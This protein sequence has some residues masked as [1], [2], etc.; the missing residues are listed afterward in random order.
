M[1]FNK[2]KKEFKTTLIKKINELLGKNL[3]TNVKN[4]NNFKIY[5][6]LKKKYFKKNILIIGD[7]LH[8]VHPIAGQG[9]NLVLRDIMK[10]KK[11]INKNIKLGMLIKESSLLKDFY[12]A[13]KP[14]NTVV[15]LGIDL[16]NSFFKENKIFSPL[17]DILLKNVDNFQFVK[18]ISQKISD[19]GL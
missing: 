15:G 13:R 7:G 6:N 1:F 8:T 17:K 14:E 3:K 4:I 12:Q 19:K 10:L 16:T 9:F 2:N 18:K 5:L 11:L